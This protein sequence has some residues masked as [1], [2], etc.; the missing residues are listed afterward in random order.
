ME[1][2]T[3]TDARWKAGME[4]GDGKRRWRRQS[5]LS[6]D[7]QPGST[8]GILHTPTLKSQPVVSRDKKN[9]LEM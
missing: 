1:M 7:V 9:E 2:E 6:P 3:E 8:L 4:S 5:W